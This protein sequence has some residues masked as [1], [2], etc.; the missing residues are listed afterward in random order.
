MIVIAK[1]DD[2]VQPHHGK[3]IFEAYGGDKNLVEVEGDHNSDR[4]HFMYDSINIFF[5]NTLQVEEI[6]MLK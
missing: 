2:F 6:N 4:P 3:S 5:K 1:G